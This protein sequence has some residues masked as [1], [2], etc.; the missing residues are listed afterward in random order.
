MTGELKSKIMTLG[1]KL[2][3]PLLGLSGS[4]YLGMGRC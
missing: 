2:V 1:N 4:L 3:P